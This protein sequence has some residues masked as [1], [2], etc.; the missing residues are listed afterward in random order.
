MVRH[1]EQCQATATVEGAGVAAAQAKRWL[2]YFSYFIIKSRSRVQYGVQNDSERIL[3]ER[4][5]AQGKAGRKRHREKGREDRKSVRERGCLEEAAEQ[6]IRTR[7][8]RWWGNHDSRW[9]RLSPVP[10]ATA[11]T[12]LLR[13]LSGIDLFRPQ[14]LAPPQPLP[15]P[16]PQWRPRLLAANNFATRTFLIENGVAEFNLKTFTDSNWPQRKKQK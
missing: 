3:I 5:D 11:P 14:L 15:L 9:G 8:A 6:L 2:E 10:A 12:L 7:H 16:L 1:R 4:Q 13:L